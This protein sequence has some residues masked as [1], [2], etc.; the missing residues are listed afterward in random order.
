MVDKKCH[1]SVVI[2]HCK[3]WLTHLKNKKVNFPQMQPIILVY[4]WNI[5]YVLCAIS[6]LCTMQY[7][8]I[9]VKIH[10]FKN[11]QIKVSQKEKPNIIHT[12]LFFISLSLYTF[13]SMHFTVCTSQDAL[14]SMHFTVCTSHYALHTMHL[15][16]CISQ[17][18]FHSM[19][20]TRCI[21][22]YAFPTIQSICSIQ[23]SS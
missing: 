5:L 13:H 18:A 15:T 7:P 23:S 12:M 16:L 3:R 6:Y 11:F 10:F 22:Q 1:M 21:S 4:S 9:I 14:H 17:Y 8:T 19:H 20:F 2:L